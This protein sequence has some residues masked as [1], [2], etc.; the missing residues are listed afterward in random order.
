[1]FSAAKLAKNSRTAKPPPPTPEKS[2]PDPH[3]P[4]NFGLDHTGMGSRTECTEPRRPCWRKYHTEAQ[5]SQRPRAGE[6][7]NY[8]AKWRENSRRGAGWRPRW[9]GKSP[10]RALL[11]LT[12]VRQ[13]PG[14]HPRPAEP[15]EGWCCAPARHKVALP[16]LMSLSGCPGAGAPRLTTTTP[17]PGLNL[18]LARMCELLCGLC[19]SA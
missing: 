15:L 16:G 4:I 12:G 14:T 18:L 9:M 8:L 19:G 13:P 3:S 7:K 5:R 10:G 11:L 17:L 1:M 6:R 2:H